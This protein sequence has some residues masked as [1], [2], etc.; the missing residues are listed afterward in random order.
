MLPELSLYH[1]LAS[2]PDTMWSGVLGALNVVSWPPVVNLPI[3]LG[4]Y[5]VNHSAPSEPTAIEK[6]EASYAREK[7]V[8]CPCGVI[9]PIRLFV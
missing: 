8:T 9:F 7:N 1:K 4:K 2:E 6:G 5:S 3:L